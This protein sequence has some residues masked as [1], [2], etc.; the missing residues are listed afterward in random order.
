MELRRGGGGGRCIT[1]VLEQRREGGGGGDKC[2]T[3]V[4]EQMRYIGNGA[5]ER[6]RGEIDD[7]H[8]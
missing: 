5:T 7:L 4:L 3:S 6:E 2:I 8:R 1:S